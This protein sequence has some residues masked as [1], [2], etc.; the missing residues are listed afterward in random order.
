MLGEQG[1]DELREQTK[2]LRF[3]GLRALRPVLEAALRNDR[4]RLAY[5]LSDGS[6]SNAIGVA[7]GVSGQSVRNWWARWR[8]L[9]LVWETGRRP[10]HLVRLS[11]LGWAVPVGAAAGSRHAKPKVAAGRSKPAPTAGESPAESPCRRRWSGVALV[12]G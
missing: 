1:F 11:D 4:E 3:L 7:V 2:W 10:K 8:R 9:G 6:S 5:A 12:H